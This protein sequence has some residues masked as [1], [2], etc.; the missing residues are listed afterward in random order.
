MESLPRYKHRLNGKGIRC[1]K[2]GWSFPV[3]SPRTLAQFLGQVIGTTRRKD[4]WTFA[5][6][7]RNP[8]WLGSHPMSRRVGS[9]GE[10]HPS[11]R[12]L[13]RLIK[14]MDTYYRGCPANGCSSPTSIDPPVSAS[15]WNSSTEEGI[16]IRIRKSR[17][18]RFSC[19][20][21]QPVI[22]RDYLLFRA[23][24]NS[25]NKKCFFFFS[26]FF[27]RKFQISFRFSMMD[28]FFNY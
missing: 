14:L 12:S 28:E 7:R 5:N 10:C 24:K 2:S 19:S 26:F 17:P 23:S 8:L 9:A 25:L 13:F 27:R 4:R 22:E 15:V 20:I 21:N 6:L 11:L 3:R 18:P 1:E 16:L